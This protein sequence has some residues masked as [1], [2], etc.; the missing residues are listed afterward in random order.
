MLFFYFIF[1]FFF[2]FFFFWGGGVC[3]F[4]PFIY[5]IYLY[6]LFNQGKAHLANIKLFHHVSLGYTCNIYT[7]KINSHDISKMIKAILP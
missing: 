5:F 7:Y 2:F 3:L 6:T 1:L 4:Y